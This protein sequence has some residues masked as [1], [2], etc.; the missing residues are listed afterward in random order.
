MT[1]QTLGV[2]VLTL[3][4]DGRAF[5][6]GELDP[7][8]GNGGSTITDLGGIDVANALVRQPD[9]KFVVAGSSAG[10][11]AL[12]R[13]EPDGTLDASFGNGGIVLGP[14]G[15][16]SSI[17]LQSNGKIVVAGAGVEV[18]R[19]HVNGSL[20]TTFGPNGNG[21]ATSTTPGS[22]AALVVQPDDKI[23]TA[24]NCCGGTWTNPSGF[25]VRFTP[26][27]AQGEL[28]IDPSPASL[29]KP[30]LFGAP[31]TAA[32]CPVPFKIPIPAN[33]SLIGLT[34]YVQGAL[35]D[36]SPGVAVPVGL[37]NAVEFRIE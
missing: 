24:G 18:V 6:S 33:Q 34:V 36:S 11:Y 7:A 19:Y 14:A 28:L 21:V 1:R 20:D 4:L 22:A 15:G 32:G 23:V 16:A 3:I 27:G 10:Q 17:G 8:F 13:Y 9:G 31:W 35:F 37:T 30:V 25:V 2:L 5:A 12:V 29:I 26:N